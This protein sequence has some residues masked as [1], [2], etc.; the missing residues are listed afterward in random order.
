MSKM[1]LDSVFETKASW[2]QHK[3][4]EA[5]Q[6]TDTLEYRSRKVHGGRDG[7][8]FV[9]PWCKQPNSVNVAC[10]GLQLHIRIVAIDD[11]GKSRT[12]CHSPLVTKGTERI[13]YNRV[14]I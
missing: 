5:R 6:K 12:N 3:D 10:E 11:R 13:Q 7:P 9:S 8:Q 1:S 2:V 4:R 14:L